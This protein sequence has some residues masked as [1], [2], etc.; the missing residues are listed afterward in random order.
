[1][2]H[3]HHL[4]RR[5]SIFASVLAEPVAEVTFGHYKA[6]CCEKN[7]EKENLRLESSR[8]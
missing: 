4:W 1:M 7:T 5:S 3:K 2:P 8:E 6:R